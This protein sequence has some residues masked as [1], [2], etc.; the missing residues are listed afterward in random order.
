M[1]LG[2]SKLPLRIEAKLHRPS[3]R[4]LWELRFPA[5]GTQCSIQFPS[6]DV[7]QARAFSV[8]AA[9]WVADFERKYSRFRDDSLI[10]EINRKAGGEWVA[11][12]S[13]TEAMLAIC[14]DLHFMTNGIMDPTLLPVIRLWYHR[15]RPKRF[16]SDGEIA[17]ALDCVGWSKVQRRPGAARLPEPGMSLD[18]GG[19]GKE[20]AVDRVA[21][22]AVQHGLVAGLIDFG[23]DLYAYG[24]PPDAPAWH[25]GLEDP[26]APGS[27]WSSVAVADRGVATSGSYQRF[28]EYQ[29]RRYGHIVD[30]RTGQP[31]VSATLAVSVVASSCLTAGAVSTAAFIM[32]RIEGMQLVEATFDA[33]GCFVQEDQTAQSMN[34]HAYLVE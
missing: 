13:E 14:D 28:F 21:A 33:E 30:P 22:L 7:E 25:I 16:P 12:D 5:M 20:Y 32:G 15:D 11:I 18:F 2:A 24:T 8:A 27:A 9:Q 31:T 17:A 29:G 23:H 6:A 19:F 26:L 1:V 3:E 10:S 4:G 34:F